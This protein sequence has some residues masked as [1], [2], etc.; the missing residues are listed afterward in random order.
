MDSSQ[1]SKIN[2]TDLSYDLRFLSG[3]KRTFL[4]SKRVF[5]AYNKTL[6]LILF[7]ATD[8]DGYGLWVDFRKLRP[9]ETWQRNGLALCDY[10]NLKQVK[11]RY[12]YT[13]PNTKSALRSHIRKIFWD[14][15]DNFI[16]QSIETKL[17]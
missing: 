13:L 15:T 17:I 7:F 2:V 1:L 12:D 6:N 10:D 8:P 3:N 16:N 11:A 9:E 4:Y 14:Y 5:A